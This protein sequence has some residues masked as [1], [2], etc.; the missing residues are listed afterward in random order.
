MTTDSM[1]FLS[2]GPALPE[3]QAKALELVFG[4]IDPR[5]RPGR[6]ANA[7]ELLRRG[8]I[9][10]E[11]VRVARRAGALAG[12][13]I[14]VP[15]PGA[16][17]LIWPP[18]G[19]GPGDDVAIED[20]LFRDALTWLLAGGSRLI[21]VLLSAQ[22]M[23]RAPCL[24]R[25]GFQHTTRLWYLRRSLRV[26]GVHTGSDALAYQTYA[27]ETAALFH[28]TLLR[29]YI[30]TLDCPELNGVRSVD[31]IIA[32]HQAQGLF[33]P[34]RWWLALHGGQPVGVLLLTEM[35]DSG[36]WDLSYLGIVP[37]ARRQG[38]GRCLAQKAIREARRAGAADL[39]L[40]VDGRNDPARQL[41]QNLGF[42]PFDQREV[43]LLLPG[44]AG[45]PSTAYPR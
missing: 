23:D 16:A 21:Q 12:A 41:Y 19:R 39:T 13:L 10:P 40:S 34:E 9:P 2:I 45:R 14:G 43:F 3:E 36:S 37:E 33:Q 30:S 29:T 7:L 11:S 6:V 35:P 25:N 1:S 24:T 38:H 27:P 32:G 31:E 5:L 8:E 18:R 22:E 4:H 42:E 28:Q 44:R 20:A 26:P 17:A 15:I